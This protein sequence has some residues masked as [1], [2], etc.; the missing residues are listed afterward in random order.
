[1]KPRSK[2]WARNLHFIA[3]A[4]YAARG[5][6]YVIVGGLAALAAFG[7]GG[8]TTDSRGALSQVLGAPGGKFLLIALAIGLLGYAAWRAVQAVYDVDNHGTDARG[9]VVRAALA[10]SALIHVGLAFFASNLAFGWGSGGG[11]GDGS[12]QE[13]TAWL[14]GQPFGPWLVAAV[15]LAIL[16][17]GIAHIIKGW[18]ADFER[19]FEMDYREREWITPVSRFGL[20]ARGVAFLLIGG[21]FIAA[22][23]QHDPSEARGLSGALQALQQQPAGW[24]PLAVL[25]LGLFA[26]GLYSVIEAAYRRVDIPV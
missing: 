13:R 25:A 12:S 6:I 23:V 19:H 11:P 17:A 7:R 14:L 22:A 24:L 1:M 8:S 18:R 3:R 4:G 16:G 15:G 21:F 5:I 9:L 20:C 2:R 10:V 26:F